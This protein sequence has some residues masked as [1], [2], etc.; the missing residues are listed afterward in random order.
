MFG[1]GTG[2][3]IYPPLSSITYHPGPAMDCAILSLHVAGA[4]SII[5]CYKFYKYNL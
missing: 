1:V 5:G 2:W 3:T 4:S